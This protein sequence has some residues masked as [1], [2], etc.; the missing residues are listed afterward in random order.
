M[1]CGYRGSNPWRTVNQIYQ[2]TDVTICRGDQLD[3]AASYVDGNFG[4]FNG[5]V[6]GTQN[7][8]GG[9]GQAV[10]AINLHTGT[11]RS[12]GPNG[13]YGHGDAYNSTPDSIGA[14]IDLSL[15]H[16]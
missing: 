9:S 15:I 4:D 6:Y 8:Y 1:V 3:R 10:S 12:F 2:A 11:N 5:Y 14:S 13:T 7:S 16:I